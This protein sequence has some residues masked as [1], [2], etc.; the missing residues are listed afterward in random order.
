MVHFAC[1][2][3]D[4]TAV[5]GSV[6]L[7]VQ[8]FGAPYRSTVSLTNECIFSDKVSY[9]GRQLCRRAPWR[10]SI[11][12]GVAGRIPVAFTRILRIVAVFLA[13]FHSTLLLFLLLLLS[14]PLR[15][16]RYIAG[17]VYDGE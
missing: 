2:P 4:F 3:V 5:V 16:T 10:T 15:A 7:I 13:M 14:V 17:I 6:R 9:A 11:N 1:A 8:A 12:I